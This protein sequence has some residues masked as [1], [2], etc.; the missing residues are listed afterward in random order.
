MVA[1]MRD[2]VEA[3][4]RVRALPA[5][6]AYA[7][8]LAAAVA[9]FLL[10]CSRAPV[11]VAGARAAA[12]SPGTPGGADGAGAFMHVLLALGAVILTARAFGGVLHRF[13][14]PAVIGE[15]LAGIALGPSL[16]G[17]V[18]PG[19][20][21]YLLPPAVAPLLGVLAQ[22][23]VL[24]FMFLVGLE[25][26][27]RL[28]RQHTRV[29][30][31]VSHTSMI[32]PFLLGATLALWL[33]PTL[34][35]DGT[36]FT[37]FALFM[38]VSMSVTAFPV[39]ARILTDLGIHRSRLGTLALSCAAIDDVSAWCLLAFVVSVA[40][41]RVGG[42]LPTLLLTVAYVA[43]MA[44]VVRP[45]VLGLVRRRWGRRP[46][47]GLTAF[48]LVAVLAC[49][50]VTELIGIHA[51]FG[52][53]SLGT[54]LSLEPQLA[55]ELR[56]RLEDLVVVLLLPAFFAFTGMRTQIGLV[57]G[58][59]W[60]ICGGIVVV[61]CVGKIGGSALAAR[62]SGL[63]WRDAAG[64]GVLMNTRGLMELIVLGIGL[65]L[66]VLSP[67]LFTMLVLMAVVTTVATVPLFQLLAP[68]HAEAPAELPALAP[69]HRP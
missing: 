4:P 30:I 49:G 34:A 1:R 41:G 65:D 52:A 38:G 46:T 24:L 66:G 18:A 37:T 67:T 60:L 21:A 9:A 35:G 14:Q 3:S 13:R 54:V 31:L 53:F 15:V 8:M 22:M 48:V 6:L 69:G 26:D 28:L 55:S 27:T 45:L 63:A 16:L 23:G 2:G 43:T 32:V 39:L 29:T 40:R 56:R 36:P 19:A 42:A 7:A 25:L 51:V 44:V 59:Q 57:R 33:F 64:L 58:A 11:I 68:Q 50:A 20:S 17:R 10:I 12:P 62:A 5:A 61:A 47:Q